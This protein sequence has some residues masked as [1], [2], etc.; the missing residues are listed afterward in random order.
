MNQTNFYQRMVC[1]DNKHEFIMVEQTTTSDKQVTDKKQWMQCKSCGYIIPIPE[2]KFL[3][4]Y[5]Q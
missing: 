5:Q 3:F 4:P 1:K 2:Q